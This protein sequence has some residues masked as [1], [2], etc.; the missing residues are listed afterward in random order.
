MEEGEFLP[1]EQED[2]TEIENNI[3][4]R[5]YRI[6]VLPTPDIIDPEEKADKG[7]ITQEAND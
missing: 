3:I 7:T 5:L 6:L 1:E 2:E 4:R